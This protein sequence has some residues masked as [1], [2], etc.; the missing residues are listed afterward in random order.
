LSRYDAQLRPKSTTLL[1][2]LSD[3]G[4]IESCS[5]LQVCG[6]TNADD[7]KHAAEQGADFIGVTYYQQ[8]AACS[9]C[10]LTPHHHCQM[11]LWVLKELKLTNVMH[12]LIPV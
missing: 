8:R 9:I 7:A 3:S 2:A 5:A 6:I 1:L 4:L 12:L 11:H 10:S